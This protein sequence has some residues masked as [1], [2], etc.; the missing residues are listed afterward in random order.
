LF[1]STKY[2]FEKLSSVLIILYVQNRFHL[3]PELKNGA[4]N[5]RF[6]TRQASNKHNTVYTRHIRLIYCSYVYT[7]REGLYLA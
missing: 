6:Y 4:I 2:T 1:D 5:Y 7:P 3:H